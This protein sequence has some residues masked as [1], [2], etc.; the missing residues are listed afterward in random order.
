MVAM[1]SLKAINIGQAMMSLS[2]R[3]GTISSISTVSIIVESLQNIK[4]KIDQE[5]RFITKPLKAS[6]RTAW[7]NDLGSLKD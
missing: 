1:H 6:V 2:C 7:I 4:E 3:N 5:T